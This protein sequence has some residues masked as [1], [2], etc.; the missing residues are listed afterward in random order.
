[1]KTVNKLQKAIRM[2]LK[3]RLSEAHPEKRTA[4]PK[5]KCFN[6]EFEKPSY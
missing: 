6:H 2:I 3:F 4:N 1:M 5:L